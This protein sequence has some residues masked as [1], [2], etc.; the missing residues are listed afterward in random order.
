MA[1]N[2][3]NAMRV[4]CRHT[5]IP[6]P[7]PLDLVVKRTGGESDPFPCDTYILMTR[8]PGQSLSGI[9]EVLSDRDEDGIKS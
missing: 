9:S 5:S 4:V 3:F 8:L 1:K 2:E 7:K 6:I